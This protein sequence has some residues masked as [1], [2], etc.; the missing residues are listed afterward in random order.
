[1]QTLQPADRAWWRARLGAFGD[2]ISVH[3]RRHLRRVPTQ[4]KPEP[5]VPIY[6]HKQ[7][8]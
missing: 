1:M 7:L 3:H 4:E 8:S 2:N 5:A 6:L